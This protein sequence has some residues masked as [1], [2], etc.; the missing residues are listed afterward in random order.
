[1]NTCLD[2][3]T[4]ISR[5]AVRCRSHATAHLNRSDR[6]RAASRA[7][8]LAKRAV[9]VCV[10]ADPET[11][12]RAGAAVTAHR[13]AHIPAHRRDEYKS[14]V[15]RRIRPVDAARII[16]DDE[17]EQD[18]RRRTAMTTHEA[19]LERVRNGATITERVAMPSRVHAVSLIGSSMAGL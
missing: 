7:G 8:M 13:L 3:G 15:T 18:R 17:A 1:M 4:Q 2:C 6:M 14:L 11:R 10:N 12:A 9:G 16:L 19:R 5:G